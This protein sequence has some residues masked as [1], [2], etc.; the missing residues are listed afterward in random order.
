MSATKPETKMSV[1]QMPA[2]VV[3]TKMWAT[4][5]SATKP[6]TKMSLLTK[7]SPTKLNPMT[8]FRA[9]APQEL[10]SAELGQM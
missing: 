6:K 9:T 7:M 2:P 10:G 4:K 3:K 8:P 5:M 1:T